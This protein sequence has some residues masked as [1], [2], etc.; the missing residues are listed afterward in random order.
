MA[1]DAALLLPTLRSKSQEKP[2]NVAD[3]VQLTRGDLETG[4]KNADYIVERELRT[5]MVHQGYI[6]PHNAQWVLA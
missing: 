2:S 5:A 4:F 1:P 6:E 3:H